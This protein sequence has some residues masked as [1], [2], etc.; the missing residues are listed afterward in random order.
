MLVWLCIGR[1][2][3]GG[4]RCRPS[5]SSSAH[6]GHGPNLAHEIAHEATSQIPSYCDAD[7]DPDIY[8]CVSEESPSRPE[9]FQSF[10][11]PSNAFCARAH[12]PSSHTSV[13]I[14]APASATSRELSPTWILGC[15]H[16]TQAKDGSFVPR[17]FH[18]GTLAGVSGFHPALQD[19]RCQGS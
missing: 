6:A 2:G 9:P 10:Q 4:K 14:Q 19:H 11:R 1:S 12:G 15:R 16:M 7:V 18:R 17:V 13:M 5:E 8:L 3:V